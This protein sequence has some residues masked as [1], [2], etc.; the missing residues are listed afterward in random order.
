M[1]ITIRSLERRLSSSTKLS[2]FASMQALRLSANAQPAVD[3]AKLKIVKR[4]LH[5]PPLDE[6]KTVFHEAL[7][8]NF[9]EVKVEIVDSPDLTEPPFHLATPGLS[10]RP[11]ILDVGGIS[12]YSNEI[13]K[14]KLYDIETLVKHLGYTKELLVIG[15]AHGPW[16]H[17]KKDSDV[18][19]NTVLNKPKSAARSYGITVDET[20]GKIEFQAL[21][22]NETRFS[23]L[24]NL[25]LSEGKPGKVLKVFAKKRTGKD[26]FIFSMRRSIENR[27]G[28]KLVGIGGAF[29]IQKGSTLQYFPNLLNKPL[30]EGSRMRR[31]NSYYL[32][33][34]SPPQI[35]VG[36]FVSANTDLDLIPHHFH[37]F[38][39]HKEGGHYLVD[40][41]P[42]T[43]EYLGYFTPGEVL[44]KVDQAPPG[45]APAVPIP[46]NY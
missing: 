2:P 19:V 1:T 4:T 46:E 14:Q 18:V 29:V 22:L 40:S 41:S 17:L 12:F 23:V 28:K 10:G 33:D 15:A 38:S 3:P 11:T 7:S 30:A 37:T 36:T 9:A 35:A 16:P 25:F 6:I 13:E 26:S 39:D 44:Y 42:E 21:P 5:V 31:V 20:R 43:V 24:G 8:K 34:S 45:K 27:Y 32:Y